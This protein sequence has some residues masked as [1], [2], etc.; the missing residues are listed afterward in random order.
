MKKYINAAVICAV[1]L[2]ACTTPFK[3]AKDGSEYKV[4]SSGKGLKAV[5][6]NFMELSSTAKYKDSILMSTAE[7][8]MPQY[9]TYDTAAF[10]VPY[11]EAFANIRVG[12][13]IVLR[14]STDSI[15]KKGQAMPFMT[16][17]QFIYQTYKI[18]G[19]YATRE[20]A[21]SAQ[22]SHVKEA[23]AKASIKQQKAIEKVLAENKVQIDAD[24]KQ[25]DEY[26]AKNNIKATKTKWGTYVSIQ[27]EGT[28]NQL[29]AK[30]IAS[31]N[32]TGKTFDSSRVFDSNT[33]PK[34][35][36]VAPYD[37]P[38]NML[39]E[40]IPGWTDALL[41]M[42]KGTK[43]T[44]YIPSTLGY[45]KNGR[46]PQIA[47]NTILVFDMEVVGVST[48]E[49]AAAKREADEKKM[50]AEQQRMMDSLQKTNPNNATAPAEKKK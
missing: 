43:A 50:Q 20:Q 40:V 32:Y 45:G 25:I 2:T 33:D 29:G 4:I 46:S 27:T 39:A 41:Q 48:E 38:L 28:G 13:S 36:H 17:G 6:G 1:A 19:I 12:D 8:G 9:G 47:P 3:K 34:F 42:K 11:K 7:D 10:P 18:L 31:V 35:N 44:V 23:T 24:C 5:T 16:K 15:I 30:D 26:L 21:D 14:M 22:K 37:V 49:E